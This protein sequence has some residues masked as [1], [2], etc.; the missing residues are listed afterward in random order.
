M[1]IKN[2]LE[3]R[4]NTKKRKPDFV[5]QDAHKKVRVK[6]SWRKPKGWNSKMRQGLRGYRSCVTPGFKSPLAVRGLTREGLEMVR[7]SRKEDLVGLV[8][9][10]HALVISSGLGTRKKIEVLE[11]ALAKNFT[12]TNYPDAQ[13]YLNKINETLE[14][15]RKEKQKEKEVKK[16]KEKEKEAAVKKKEEEE[17]KAQE[18]EKVDSSEKPTTEK[19]E[20]DTE[21]S[22]DDLTK[23][24][25]EKRQQ[26]EKKEKDKV[27][28]KKS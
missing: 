18:E 2:L 28:T 14:K 26:E 1:D 16:E 4:K 13:A 3:V 8:P 10:K 19:K 9:E 15:K 22:L 12:V 7:I 6:S 20:T 21:K 17:K 23:E 27:L 25:E 11:V 5:R 24:E